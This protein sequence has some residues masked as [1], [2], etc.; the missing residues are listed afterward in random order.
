VPDGA[1][2]GNARQRSCREA[3]SVP[4]LIFGERESSLGGRDQDSAARRLASYVETR[5]AQAFTIVQG[6]DGP[7]NVAIV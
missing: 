1:V 4:G 5:F 7:C 2:S 3:Y 6:A